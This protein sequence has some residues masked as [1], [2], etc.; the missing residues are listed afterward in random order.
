[1]QDEIMV[2]LVSTVFQIDHY[3]MVFESP[4]LHKIVMED[5]EQQIRF[6]ASAHAGDHLNHAVSARIDEFLKVSFSFYL[7]C[8]NI[9]H[10]LIPCKYTLLPAAKLQLFPTQTQIISKYTGLTEEQIAKL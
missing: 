7:H 6:P 2:Y 1:M 8:K 3:D 9:L 10:S 4:M 5:G